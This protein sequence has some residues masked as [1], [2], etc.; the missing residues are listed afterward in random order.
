[1]RWSTAANVLLVLHRQQIFYT[2][3]PY[4]NWATLTLL[5]QGMFHSYHVWCGVVTICSTAPVE[6]EYPE[7]S[8]LACNST[9]QW[10]AYVSSQGIIYIVQRGSSTNNNNNNNQLVATLDAAQE[11]GMVDGVADIVFRE[12]HCELYG[13]NTW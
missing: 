8:R 2:E 13:T 6:E 9:A 12:S 4:N 10:I 5:W 1:V 11:L 7:W 3:N